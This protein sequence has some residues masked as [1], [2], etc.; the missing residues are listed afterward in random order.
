MTSG[1]QMALAGVTS[2]QM[3]TLLLYAV[4]RFGI[5]DMTPEVAAAIVGAATVMG[6]TFSHYLEKWLLNRPH[7]KRLTDITPQEAT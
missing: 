6:G 7:T 5:D 2:S 3:V 1:Q 4:H